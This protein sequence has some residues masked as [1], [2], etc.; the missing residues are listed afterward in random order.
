MDLKAITTLLTNQ[1]STFRT[2]LSSAS[3]SISGDALKSKLTQH[4][5]NLVLLARDNF[6]PSNDSLDDP[7]EFLSDRDNP[8]SSFS[9]SSS[10]KRRDPPAQG[11]MEAVP[12]EKIL[13]DMQIGRKQEVLHCLMGVAESE[14][15]VDVEERES[16]RVEKV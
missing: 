1:E 4:Y 13:Q 2:I 6:P 12:V 9:S 7:F 5:I 10:R 3:P 14:K 8:Y 15:G 16:R 11:Q